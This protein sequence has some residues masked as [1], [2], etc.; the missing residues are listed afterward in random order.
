MK[1]VMPKAMY[2]TKR[3]GDTAAFPQVYVDVYVHVFKNGI[4][5]Q[6]KPLGGVLEMG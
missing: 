4:H 2:V 1:S 6:W 3:Q 5:Q